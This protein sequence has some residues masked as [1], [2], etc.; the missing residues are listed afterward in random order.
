MPPNVIICHPMSSVL[1]V[2]VVYGSHLFSG[3]SQGSQHGLSVHALAALAVQATNGNFSV[4]VM[5]LPHGHW[6][7]NCMIPGSNEGHREQMSSVS[8]T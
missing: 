4:F 5:V 1:I 2:V 7:S 8:Q 6:L 3:G